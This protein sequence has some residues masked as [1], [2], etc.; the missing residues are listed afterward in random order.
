MQIASGNVLECPIEGK[1]HKKPTMDHRERLALVP[2]A[3]YT[4]CNE[5][6]RSC[7]DRIVPAGSG[8]P[9]AECA[10]GGIGW[11]TD[12]YLSGMKILRIL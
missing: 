4:I 7:P 1:I 9:E 12:R 3:A 11:I 6:R 5:R 10:K 8:K 2:A